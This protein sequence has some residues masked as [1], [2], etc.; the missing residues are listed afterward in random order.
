MKGS[1][2]IAKL[3]YLEKRRIQIL[4][5]VYTKSNQYLF[6]IITNYLFQR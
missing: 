3:T 2:F 1:F 4:E 6:L 5:M